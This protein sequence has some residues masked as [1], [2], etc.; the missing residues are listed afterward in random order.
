MPGIYAQKL[1]KDGVPRWYNDG[2]LLSENSDCGLPDVA[3][4]SDGSGIFVWREQAGV[5]AARVT[6]DGSVAWRSNCTCATGDCDQP[7]IAFV[8]DTGYVV[9]RDGKQ[10]HYD[11]IDLSGT[12]T[13]MGTA[14][15][16]SGTYPYTYPLI[17]SDGSRG[18][19]VAAR[20]SN[21]SKLEC[22]YISS[23]RPPNMGT[24]ISGGAGDWITS[25]DLAID[26]IPSKVTEPLNAILAYTKRNSAYVQKMGYNPSGNK[27]NDPWPNS[28]LNAMI[29]SGAGYYGSICVASDS[30]ANANPSFGGGAILAWDYHDMI[31]FVG[32][33]THLV[34]T[35]RIIWNDTN[36]VLSKQWSIPLYLIDS[37]YRQGTETHPDIVWK[38]NPNGNSILGVVAWQ[39]VRAPWCQYGDAIVAQCVNY[40]DTSRL[41]AIL[42]N[43]IGESVSPQYGSTAQ[44]SIQIERCPNPSG[45]AMVT[46]YW[47][48]TRAGSPI[49]AGTKI[50]DAMVVSDHNM[51]IRKEGG[52]NRL[53]PAA[54]SSLLA[55][56]YPNPVSQSRSSGTAIGFEVPLD[57]HCTIRLYD[58]LGRIVSVI[59]SGW[60]KAGSYTCTV[61]SSEFAGLPAGMY[62]YE[63]ITGEHRES[64]MMTVVR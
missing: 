60:Y 47:L 48:D 1:D 5:R 22:K 8:V 21:W 39:D 62:I 57:G 3:V 4:Y 40:A 52:T 64:K 26:P 14:I 27:M 38:C 29:T 58:A 50:D 51:V 41:Q 12:V 9:Y 36:V 54:L 11:F 33:S 63:L 15:L 19:Y 45:V 10:I 43:P 13:N 28:T 18:C 35:Q 49:V 2:V 34:Q 42:W 20:W 24:T 32:D 25:Y 37:T 56:N 6:A 46:G 44:T 59:A 30:V 17:C 55:Q 7:R 16:N 53:Q 31:M 61:G 23:Y